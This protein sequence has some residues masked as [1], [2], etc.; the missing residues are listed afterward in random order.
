MRKKT[1]FHY[2]P[3]HVKEENVA[4]QTTPL[5]GQLVDVSTVRPISQVTVTIT[6]SLIRG[7]LRRDVTVVTDANGRFSVNTSSWSLGMTVSIGK[8]LQCAGKVHLGQ[9]NLNGLVP[10]L[11]SYRGFI[12]TTGSKL[13][14]QYLGAIA[15]RP[16]RIGCLLTLS[17]PNGI[18]TRAATLRGWCP[19]PLDDG[20]K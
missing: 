7:W 2:W 15:V 19:R 13:A 11:V 5:A 4:E 12:A 16:I 17:S 6:P 18:R 8:G 14:P 20:A 3:A 9:P 1:A 10:R